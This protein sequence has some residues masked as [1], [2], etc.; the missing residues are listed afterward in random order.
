MKREVKDVNGRHFIIET[1]NSAAEL[2]EITDSRKQ[3]F[4]EARD[5]GDDDWCGASWEEARHMLQFGWDK[6][7]N[8]IKSNIQ[9]LEKQGS[10]KKVQFKNDIIG[11]TPNVPN[12]ILGVPQSMINTS[13]T[14]KKAK[15]INVML[16]LGA[17]C[18]V[19]SNEKIEY[20]SKVLEKLYSLEKA[21][22]RIRIEFLNTFN[23]RSGRGF[24]QNTYAIKYLLKNENQPFDLK[25]MAFPIIHTAM[26]RR[27][28]F[29]WYERLPD[30]IHLGGYGT[31]IKNCGDI[32]NIKNVLCS[33]TNTYMILFGDDLDEIFKNIK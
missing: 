23:G 6:P 20:G 33:D 9:R 18:G 22:F 2:M 14:Y 5:R 19:S 13:V 10:M 7:V 31:S 24:E 29:D 16:D 11:F 30:A 12:A 15:V 28:A 25:R 21:G 27:I 1:F 4:G 8:Q 26:F 17:T 32:R 3:N